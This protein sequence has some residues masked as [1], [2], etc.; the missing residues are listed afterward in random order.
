MLPMR[1]EIVDPLCPSTPPRI[2]FATTTPSSGCIEGDP[3]RLR[4]SDFERH[5]TGQ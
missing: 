1:E 4:E 5:L 2:R 3:A